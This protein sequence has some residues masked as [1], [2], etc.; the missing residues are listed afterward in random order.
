MPK[1]PRVIFCRI[2]PHWHNIFFYCA[3]G[4]IFWDAC[5]CDPAHAVLEDLCIMFFCKIP[6]IWEIFV[7]LVRHEAKQRFLKV[8]A[9][10]RYCVDESCSDG[11]GK[12][13]AELG[14]RHSTSKRPKHFPALVDMLP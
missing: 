4:F 3:K 11:R 5:I 6:V 8:R 1:T 9:R 14:R 12:R 10:A 7:A 13:N 2:R